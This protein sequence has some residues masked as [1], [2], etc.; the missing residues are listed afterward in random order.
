MGAA[1]G[2]RRAPG[3]KFIRTAVRRFTLDQAAK[4]EDLQRAAAEGKSRPI[5]HSPRALA[6]GIAERHG[7]LSS[8]NACATAQITL[9]L[10]QI[11]R[12]RSIAQGA[13]AELNSGE[14]KPARLRVF[15]QQD[16]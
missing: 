7:A 15:R 10:A 12:P 9:Q 8:N 4:L 14:W 6:A 13:T 11:R 3:G 2:M 16:R 1:L 5:R